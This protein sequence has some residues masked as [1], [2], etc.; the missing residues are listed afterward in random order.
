MIS[1][2]DIIMAIV[3]SVLIGYGTES[4]F[5][6]VGVFILGAAIRSTNP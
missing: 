2:I 3:G 1:V 4:V 6:G 5:V